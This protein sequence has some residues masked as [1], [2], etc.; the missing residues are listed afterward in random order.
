MLDIT[1][2]DEAEVLA[3]L[4][5]RARPQGLGFLHFTPEPMNRD[6]AAAILREQRRVDYLKG[7]V[8]KVDFF[9]A[10][11][12]TSERNQ[13]NQIQ[14]DWLYDHDNGDGAAAEVIAKLRA[15][16]KETK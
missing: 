7:R 2:L 8:M 15:G 16:S 3:A 5:N 11:R 4:Y 9:D 13:P 14:Y 12:P 10:S 1:G 6:E